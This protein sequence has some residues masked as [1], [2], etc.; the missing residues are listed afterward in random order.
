MTRVCRRDATPFRACGDE[1]RVPSE[2]GRGGNRWAVHRRPGPEQAAP[3]G[4]YSSR[5]G[6]PGR[7]MLRLGVWRW[8]LLE[9]RHAEHLR[10]PDLHLP[11]VELIE[12]AEGVRLAGRLARHGVADEVIG[13]RLTAGPV[14][15]LPIHRL[16]DRGSTEELRMIG[17]D[18]LLLPELLIDEFEDVPL[19]LLVGGA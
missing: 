18:A 9:G 11:L 17:Q 7:V 14:G 6:N 4:D 8:L 16:L 3:G 15:H 13:Q 10:V 19:E 2:P 1:L 12:R 5:A